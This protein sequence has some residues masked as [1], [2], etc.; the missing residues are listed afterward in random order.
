[1]KMYITAFSWCTGFQNGWSK[2][3]LLLIYMYTSIHVGIYIYIY[4]YIY[5]YTNI[6]IGV[7]KDIYTPIC[8]KTMELTFK[9]FLLWLYSLNFS[10]TPHF[11]CL[12]LP[13]RSSACRVTWCIV[14]CAVTHSYV[15]HACKVTFSHVWRVWNGYQHGSSTNFFSKKR[16]FLSWSLSH[17]YTFTHPDGG[18]PQ[19]GHV[20]D[21]Q[22]HT[23][24]HTLTVSLFAVSFSLTRIHT[25]IQTAGCRD[26]GM[27]LTACK[28]VAAAF[29]RIASDGQPTPLFQVYIYIG[30]FVYACTYIYVYIYIYINSYTY[31]FTYI[32]MYIYTCI[33]VCLQIYNYICVYRIHI[34]IYVYI[35]AYISIYKYMYNIYIRVHFQGFLL[36]VSFHLNVFLLA[37]CPLSAGCLCV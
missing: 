7:Y 17:S 13:Y 12:S 2:D 23:H 31:I 36:F 1:M 20:A 14:L 33:H 24:M 15:K 21:S 9:K 37:S 32:D 27:S 28:V 35:Y 19:R 10:K 22:T 11:L 3:P 29:A 16:S 30:R 4:I 6:H 34:C 26:G 18:M 5:M 25:H 8:V